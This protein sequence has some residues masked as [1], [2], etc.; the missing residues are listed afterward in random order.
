MSDHGD[1]ISVLAVLGLFGVN[2]GLSGKFGR[3]SRR[4]SDRNW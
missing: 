4:P 3:D 2:A 1:M